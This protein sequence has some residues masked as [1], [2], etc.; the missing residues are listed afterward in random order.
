MGEGEAEGRLKLTHTRG[1]AW[2]LPE[3]SDLGYFCCHIRLVGQVAV[4]FSN[5]GRAEKNSEVRDKQCPGKARGHSP[6]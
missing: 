4:K 6:S 2:E 3:D 5:V 1:I